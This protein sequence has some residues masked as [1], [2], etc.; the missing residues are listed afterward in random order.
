MTNFLFAQFLKYLNF[1]DL[2]IVS[3]IKFLTLCWYTGVCHGFEVHFHHFRY[4]DGWV[5]ATD[6]CAQIEKL[7][8]FFGKFALKNIQYG[9][10]LVFFAGKWYS[11]GSQNRTFP[12]IEKVE[13][14]KSA[15]HIPVQLEIK[16]P[17]YPNLQFNR[18][19]YMD[20]VADRLTDKNISKM[21][22]N[23]F[24]RVKFQVFKLVTD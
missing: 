21:R 4:I 11:E 7:V 14:A 19:K 9:Q 3:E 17:P 12:G 8:C 1:F 23:N 13:I 20:D 18:V 16:N 15:W 6:Q 10:N 24:K 2:F 22:E 5:I